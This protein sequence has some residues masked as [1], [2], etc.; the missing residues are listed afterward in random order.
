MP[1]LHETEWFT[2]VDDQDQFAFSVRIR[3]RCWVE[4][5]LCQTLEVYDTG[6]A[7]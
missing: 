1:T 2:E 5:T 7:E 3:S 6:K 4:Q